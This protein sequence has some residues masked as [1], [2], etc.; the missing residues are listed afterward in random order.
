MPT[1]CATSARSVTSWSAISLLYFSRLKRLWWS[2]HSLQLSLNLSSTQS[3][4]VA[5]PLLQEESW[6]PIL[7]LGF[8]PLIWSQPQWC[9]RLLL[10]PCL[11]S[12]IQKQKCRRLSRRMTYIS[13]NRKHSGHVSPQ[14]VFLHSKIFF[15]WQTLAMLINKIPS[16]GT[17]IYAFAFSPS[18]AMFVSC[19][20]HNICLV[21]LHKIKPYF[22]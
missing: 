17:K 18:S 12:C 9:R 3:W 16:R 22:L 6:L 19:W 15:S 1:T 21:L 20:M 8:N 2:D 5:W 11:K 4:Q 10:W 14:G 13:T 7:V